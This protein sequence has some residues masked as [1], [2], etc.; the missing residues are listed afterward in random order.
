MIVKRWADEEHVRQEFGALHPSIFD[1]NYN[2]LMWKRIEE[3]KGF[4]YHWL[5]NCGINLNGLDPLGPDF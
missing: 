3:L 1:G 5:E 4:F 2:R